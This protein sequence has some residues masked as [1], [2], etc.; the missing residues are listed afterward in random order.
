[1]A[2]SGGTYRRE[3]AENLPNQLTPPLSHAIFLLPDAGLPPKRVAKT[4]Y[5]LLEQPKIWRREP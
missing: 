3:V 5:T 4:E 2:V 1:M